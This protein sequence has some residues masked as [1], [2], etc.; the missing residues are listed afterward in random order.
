MADP[1]RLGKDDP[2]WDRALCADSAPLRRLLPL[3]CLQDRL[4][5]PRR[6]RGA[7]ADRLLRPNNAGPCCFCRRRELHLCHADPLCAVAV[8]PGQCGS[9]V[10]DQYDCSRFCRWNVEC[11]LRPSFG[12]GER[13]LLDHDHDGGSVDYRPLHHHPVRQSDRCEGSL[14]LASPGNDLDWSLGH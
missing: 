11:A 7:T 6:P 4:Y 3:D 8:D 9:G 5:D 2:P 13:V 12:Q 14:F 10:S 1:I